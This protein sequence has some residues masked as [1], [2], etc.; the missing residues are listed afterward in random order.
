M[1]NSIKV[2]NTFIQEAVISDP[3]HYCKKILTRKMNCRM[4]NKVTVKKDT[5]I[6]IRRLRNQSKI[7]GRFNRKAS[8][9]LRLLLERFICQ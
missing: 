1:S 9:V 4:R 6:N 5:A 7:A 3:N 8:T 2:H